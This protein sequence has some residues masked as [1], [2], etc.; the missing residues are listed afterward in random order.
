MTQASAV[1]IDLG[2]VRR[3]RT[4]SK[5]AD[6]PVP[7]PAVPVAWCA[8]VVGYAFVPIWMMVPCWTAFC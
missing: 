4:A 7:A 5:R 2:E 1:I 8:P 6:A 3:R